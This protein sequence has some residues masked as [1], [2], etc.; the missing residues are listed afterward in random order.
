MNDKDKDADK[1]KGD[2]DEEKNEKSKGD[3]NQ[4]RNDDDSETE[5]REEMDVDDNETK[6]KTNE[7]CIDKRSAGG[8]CDTWKSRGFCESREKI[9]EQY[10]R[11]TCGTCKLKGLFLDNVKVTT[12]CFHIKILTA[13]AFKLFLV[14]LRE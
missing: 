6:K 4:G 5:E 3:D 11:K 13:A 12:I 14:K 2:D 9:R 10:C 8:M 1:R 7:S